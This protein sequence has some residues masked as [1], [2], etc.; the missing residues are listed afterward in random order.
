[1]NSDFSAAGAQI[2]DIYCSSKY[3]FNFARI[4]VETKTKITIPK[5]G[6]DEGEDIVVTGDTR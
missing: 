6:S 5:I 1:M 2:S 4:E 3:K